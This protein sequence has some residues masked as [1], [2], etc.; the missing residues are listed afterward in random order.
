MA[1][2]LSMELLELLRKGEVEDKAGFLG[3]AVRRLAQA[4]IEAEVEQVIGAGRYERN[5]T[6]TNQ[7]NGSTSRRWDTAAGSIDL[8][9][10]RR[11]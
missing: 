6:R 1:D 7:R 4:I 9:I 3:K 11:P 2:T 10:P 5:E 8:A